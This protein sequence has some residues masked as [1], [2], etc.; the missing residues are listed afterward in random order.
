MF[1]WFDAAPTGADAV[2]GAGN[3]L[4]AVGHGHDLIA[5]RP[6]TVAAATLQHAEVP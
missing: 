6:K 1:P 4:P 2:S 3:A 5:A